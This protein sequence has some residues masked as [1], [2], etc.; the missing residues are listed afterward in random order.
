MSLLVD[1]AG[2][3]RLEAAN[4]AILVEFTFRLRFQSRLQNE[5]LHVLIGI[6]ILV[7]MLGKSTVAW[8]FTTVISVFGHSG[9]QCF[10][11]L[12]NIEYIAFFAAYCI[13]QVFGLAGAE[14]FD[15]GKSSRLFIVFY[16]CS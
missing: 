15:L 11:C 4:P 2:F 13:Y 1:T 7:E 14:V 6:V 8:S 16:H 12:A 10:S 9:L 3:H 5:Y